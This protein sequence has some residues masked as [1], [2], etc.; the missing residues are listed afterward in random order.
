[1]F[2]R[3]PLL[4]LSRGPMRVSH[5]TFK[6]PAYPS[7]LHKHDTGCTYVLTSLNLSVK[8]PVKS[9]VYKKVVTFKKYI[10]KINP[11]KDS[12]EIR[13]KQA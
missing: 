5:L 10:L 8:V 1:M 11:L 7:S 4:V 9:K 3:K 12:T 6:I 2:F 13:L